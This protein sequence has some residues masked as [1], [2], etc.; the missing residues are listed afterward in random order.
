MSRHLASVLQTI[1]R[2]RPIGQ[3][4]FG[5]LGARVAA[6]A[7]HARLFVA[8]ADPVSGL[9]RSADA[10]ERGMA[11]LARGI[12][13]PFARRGLGLTGGL[14]WRGLAAMTGIGLTAALVT[15]MPQANEELRL[16]SMTVQQDHEPRPV[17]DVRQEPRANPVAD[18]IWVRVARPGT[19][20]GL[21]TPE[22]AR[23][24]PVHEAYRNQAGTRR[25]DSLTFGE[26]N[27]PQPH[28]QLAL[29]PGLGQQPQPFV[30]ALVRE[31]AERG[32]SVQRSGLPSA[33][34]TRFGTADASD[35]TLSDGQTSRACI[36][37]R[38]DAGE[39]PLGLSGWWCGGAGRPADR[40]Q[41]T[42]MLDRLV[43]ISAGDDKAL[44]AAFSRTE[45]DRQS[46]C[47]P[48]RPAAGG[49]KVSWLDADGKAPALKTA[50]R[51]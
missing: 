25:Q 43:L 36:A 42:C 29:V 39:T 51:R 4:I 19:L 40:Q 24:T 9:I 8:G 16:A 49:R 45:L 31:A 6:L 7:G 18:E 30:I 2:A 26:F 3:P 12:S 27:Q 38:K 33:I 11:R 35:V 15:A 28:L 5:A 46:A 41:L 44:Q 21:E 1:G 37:F 47:A 23:Q 10:V 22:L 13:R 32:M 34:R 48:P 20:F 14:L 50:N 17:R